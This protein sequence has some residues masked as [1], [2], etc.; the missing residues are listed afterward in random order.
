MKRRFD[1]M[2]LAVGFCAIVGILVIITM[3]LAGI[4]FLIKF[5]R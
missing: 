2:S 5:V 3:I 4:E 1:F